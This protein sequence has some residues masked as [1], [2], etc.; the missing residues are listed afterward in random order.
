MKSTFSDQDTYVTDNCNLMICGN[1]V[2]KWPETPRDWILVKDD[3]PNGGL[4]ASD[5]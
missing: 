5:L 1:V 4:C 3:V 2:H